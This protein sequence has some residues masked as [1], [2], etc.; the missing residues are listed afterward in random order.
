[1]GHV[2][3][4]VTVELV[5]C[6]VDPLGQPSVGAADSH[7]R[8][9][10][11][12]HRGCETMSMPEVAN[13][14]WDCWFGL[15]VYFVLLRLFSELLEKEKRYGGGDALPTVGSQALLCPSFKTFYFILQAL[16][17]MLRDWDSR[18]V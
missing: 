13:V 17:L 3:G 15:Q 5:H 4:L 18:A 9:V 11:S 6:F 16:L 1:M 12:V 8:Q 2:K 14:K 10:V 7:C